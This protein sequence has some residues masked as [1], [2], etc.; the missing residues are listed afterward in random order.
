[1]QTVV[2]LE[3]L[4]LVFPNRSGDTTRVGD[5]YFDFQY[6]RWQERQSDSSAEVAIMNAA[7]INEGRTMSV[8]STLKIKSEVAWP[9]DVCHL[10]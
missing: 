2:L 10:V 4:R 3:E 1:M 9:G 5:T 6:S 7:I 8:P